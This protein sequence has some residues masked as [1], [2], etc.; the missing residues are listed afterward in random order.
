MS[1]GA[2]LFTRT[3]VLK[4]SVE[5]KGSVILGNGF[6]RVY[7]TPNGVFNPDSTTP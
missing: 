4:D 2:P 6:Q 1:P 7:A 3:I 5:V